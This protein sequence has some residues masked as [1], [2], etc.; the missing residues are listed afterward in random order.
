MHTATI[1]STAPGGAMSTGMTRLAALS[2]ERAEPKA[3]TRAKMGI[4][5]VGSDAT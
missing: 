5:D 2:T 1:R 3:I 4:T